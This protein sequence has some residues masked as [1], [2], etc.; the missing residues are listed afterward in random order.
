MKLK[1]IKLFFVRYSGLIVIIIFMFILIYGMGVSLLRFDVANRKDTNSD[2]FSNV[3]FV[4]SA[5]LASIC[6]SWM[7]TFEPNEDYLKNIVK[8]S[9]ETFVL[10]A[11][12]FLVSA[13]TIYTSA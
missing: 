7:K 4:V 2:I 9:G 1:K 13:M 8:N 5:A 11:L 6:L 10:S 12:L 3:G